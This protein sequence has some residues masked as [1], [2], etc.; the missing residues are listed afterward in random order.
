M[1]AAKASAELK[2]KWAGK[3]LAHLASE[4]GVSNYTQ[5]NYAQALAEFVRWHRE[6][7]QGRR[8]G[9][10]CSGMIFARTCGFWGGTVG[11]RRE[12]EP[13]GDT[14]S[15]QRA[16]DFLSPSDSQRR[17]GGFAH[18]EPVAA[19]TGEA[20]AEIFDGA[21]DGE[22]AGSTVETAGNRAEK[23]R[24]DGADARWRAIGT[25]RF[26]RRFIRADCASANC[27]G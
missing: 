1:T 27:A 15:L 10:A 9:S 3:F 19:E 5:R 4:R 23:T 24:R 6:E 22:P 21:T 18:Q 26:W 12:L 2:D 8:T 14:A 13:R 17:G 25:W 11:A 7:R 20:T 16:A